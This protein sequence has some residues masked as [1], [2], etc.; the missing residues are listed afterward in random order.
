MKVICGLGNPGKQYFETRHNVGF[1]VVDELAQRHQATFRL[2]S[3][4]QAEIA[5]F[6]LAG[7]KVMLV[8]PMTFMNE[9]GKS[10]R[11]IADYYQLE[12]EDLL[13]VFDD[14]DLQVGKLRL[15]A[16]GSAGGHNGIKSIISHLNT[17]TFN[18]IKIGIGRPEHQ[19]VVQHVLSPFHKTEYPMIKEA[20]SKAGDAIDFFI[21]TDDF[22]QTMNQFNKK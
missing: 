4:F 8:K 20:V 1:M 17:K 6:L 7:E 13:I 19:T 15:R 12:M 14:L 11:L 21:E 5:T 3:K 16:S 22:N 18:R 2:E 10:L 9:S